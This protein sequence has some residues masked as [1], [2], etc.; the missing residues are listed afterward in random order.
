VSFTSA[1]NRLL[2]GRA[3]RA[4]LRHTPQSLA[5][6][7]ARK[8]YEMAGRRLFGWIAVPIHRFS[9]SFPP[10]SV[11]LLKPTLVVGAAVGVLFLPVPY[12]FPG[13]GKEVDAKQFVGQLWQVS[14]ASVALTIAVV[15]FA[16]QI[17]S[18]VRA[19]SLRE[20]TGAT[21][22]LLVVYVGVSSIIVQALVLLG[23]GYHGVTRWAGTWATEL[24]ILSILSVA[25]LFAVSLRAV[26]PRHLHARR[27]REVK[28][29]VDRTINAEAENRIAFALLKNHSEE[30][31]YRFAPYVSNAEASGQVIY[32]SKDGEIVDIR[33]DLIERL[34]ERAGD[35]GLPMV[36]LFP[37]NK[38]TS[39]VALMV[40]DDSKR[41]RRLAR[42]AISVSSKERGGSA[43]LEEALS[44]LHEEALQAIRNSRTATFKDILNVYEHAIIGFPKAW[45]RLGQEYSPEIAGGISLFGITSIGDVAR[46]IYEQ[47]AVAAKEGQ[48]EI[49]LKVAYLPIS[50]AGKAVEFRAVGLS[51]RML[52]LYSEIA[53]LEPD[54]KVISSEIFHEHIRMNLFAHI[55]IHVGSVLKSEQLAVDV[56]KRNIPLLS[57][58]L[59]CATKIMKRLVDTRE[60]GRFEKFHKD[61]GKV[62]RYWWPT[63]YPIPMVEPSPEAAL[64]QKVRDVKHVSHFSLTTWLLSNYRKNL[65]DVDLRGMA[66][67]VLTTYTDPK[68]ILRL[69]GLVESGGHD[70]LLHDWILESLPSGEAYTIDSQSYIVDAVA[71]LLAAK[72]DAGSLDMSAWLYHYGAPLSNSLNSLLNEPALLENLGVHNFN[73]E[74]A[75]LLKDAIAKAISWQKEKIDDSLIESDLDDALVQDFVKATKEAWTEYRVGVGLMA[76]AGAYF[77][78]STKQVGQPFGRSAELGDK[79]WFSPEN[80]VYGGETIGA[81]YGRSVAFGENSLIT[82]ALADSRD[83]GCNEDTMFDAISCA[84]AELLRL[85][86]EPSVVIVGDRWNLLNPTNSVLE[87]DIELPIT[88]KRNFV[89]AYFGIPLVRLSNVPHLCAYVVDLKRWASWTQDLSKDSS[90][91]AVKLKK[92]SEAEALDEVEGNDAL[93]PDHGDMVARA[94]ELRKLIRIDVLEWVEFEQLDRHAALKVNLTRPRPS[95]D[96]LLMEESH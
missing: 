22:F 11:T 33:L 20:L 51:N 54:G 19:T 18:A 68:E 32:S 13:L 66:R 86:Y 30:V 91:L 74:R 41:S 57:S 47:S 46:Q 71:I 62:T 72:F 27:L 44:A 16:F 80:R 85:G 2:K 82:T 58:A 25:Y 73:P 76:W 15:L 64:I 10:L 45:Q 92:Y 70:R 50:M 63:F 67:V 61:W 53:M 34:K 4:L 48:K 43:R 77:E 39:D 94:R 6:R 59:T 89:G 60:A 96:D 88:L 28:R 38:I 75:E 3:A 31:G 8:R 37:G 14:A 40:V 7:A 90:G 69:A 84:L 9:S 49:L 1:I 95:T 35:E 52:S 55:D 81:E 24:A 87:F 79:S 56:R 93:F 23:V 83:S 17:V 65:A 21:P 26:D 78:N 12:Y 36:R 29:E 42:R 5:N